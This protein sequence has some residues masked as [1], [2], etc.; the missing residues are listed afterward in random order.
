MTS[1]E[2]QKII[3]NHNN[4]IIELF[5]KEIDEYSMLLI[6]KYHNSEFL[7]AKFATDFMIDGYKFIRNKY[8][9]DIVTATDNKTL[10]FYNKIYFNEGLLNSEEFNYN[11]ENFYNLFKNLIISQETITVE[12]N[13]DDVID[14]YV[15]KVED[16]SG[17]II[18]MKCFD[19]DGVVFKDKV[20]VNL[21]YVS[22]VTIR[23]RY[24]SIMSKYIDF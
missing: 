5:R 20:K 3:K 11:E 4:K 16:I 19:G 23:D 9:T 8:I 14:Y 13:F 15:G 17:K 2:I 7:C 22:M 1:N 24:T 12:C 21:D 6:P 10:E 18:I